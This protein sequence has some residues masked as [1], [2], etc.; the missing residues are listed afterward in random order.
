MKELTVISGKGGT[1]KTSLVACMASLAKNKV[2][3][4]CDVDAADLHLILEPK[5]R[6]RNEFTGAKLAAIDRETCTRCGK[7]LEL[8][9]FEAISSDFEVDELSCEGCGVCERFCPEGA[10]SLVERI[11][12][13]WFVSDTRYGTMVHARLKPGEGNSGRLVTLVRQR[14]RRIAEEEGHDLIL[15]DGPP[16]LD[17]PVI[18]SIAGADCVLMVTEPTWSGLHDLKR[19]DGLARHFGLKRL[20]CINKFD[21]NPGMSRRIE[22]YC[23]GNGTKPLG[24]IPYD[25]IVTEAMVHGGSVIE[26][27][28]GKVSCEI[29]K[30]WRHLTYELA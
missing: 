11:S 13:E 14:A 20:A 26:Y 3:A 23:R 24:L 18:S 8:C 19:V 16:G 1:G 4:D 5:I 28:G 6:E 25:P 9:R 15:V 12:G 30:L 22:D 10:I 2:L 29:Q 21:L 7:C 27:S 17:C